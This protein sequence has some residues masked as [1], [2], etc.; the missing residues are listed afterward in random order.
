MERDN[1]QWN[2]FKKREWRLRGFIC[3]LAVITVPIGISIIRLHEKSENRKTATV[4]QI[5]KL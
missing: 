4:I 3:L 2:I 1:W 5:Q